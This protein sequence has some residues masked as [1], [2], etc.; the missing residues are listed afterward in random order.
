MH[1]VLACYHF[2]NDATRTVMAHSETPLPDAH[3]PW[4][5]GIYLLHEWVEGTS[6][7]AMEEIRH[8]NHWTAQQANVLQQA[9]GHQKN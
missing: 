9:K 8:I 2:L 3:H 1:K 4:H 6:Q 7:A 5:L